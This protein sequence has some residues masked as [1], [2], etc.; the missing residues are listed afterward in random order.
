M[1]NIT[2]DIQYISSKIDKFIEVKNG[3]KITREN[4]NLNKDS[5][6]IHIKED[7]NVYCEIISNNEKETVFFC[8]SNNAEYI[9][10]HE[11]P[12]SIKK[13]YIVRG[14]ILINGVR[15]KEGEH[16]R[17]EKATQHDIL[18]EKETEVIVVLEQN[19]K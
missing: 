15:C 5:S 4:F 14:E 9:E 2:K 6:R 11:H 8:K 12:N 3:Y 7:R 1:S 18:Y 13:F 19:E 17:L 16:Y 10:Q